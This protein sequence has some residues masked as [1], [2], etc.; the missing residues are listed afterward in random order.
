MA[1]LPIDTSNISARKSVERALAD[2]GGV[3]RLEATW[4]AREWLPP[5]GRLGLPDAKLDAG[6]RGFICERWLGSTTKADNR[7]SL[8][9]EGL[10]YLALSD[11]ARVTLR[12]AVAN[13]PVAIMGAAYAASHDGLSRL[14]KIF[15]FADRFPFHLH[16][17]QEHASLVGRHQK[18]EA[19]WYP[20]GVD[21]GPHPEA[22]LGLHPSLVEPRRHD[23]LLPFL[24]DWNSNLILKHSRAELQVA[25]EGFHVASGILHSPGSALTFELQ[26]DSDVLLMFSAV[27][28]G[29][30]MSKDFLFKDVRPEDRARYGERFALETVDWE[31]N[32]DPLFFE[33]HHTSPQLIESSR[34]PGG[35]AFWIYYNTTK[36][37][38]KKIVV[39]PGAKYTT[40]ERGVYN[41]IVWHGKGT[42]AGLTVD[43]SD[44]T[45]D[46]LLVTHD[47]AV[48]AT[49]IENTGTE[50]MVIVTF[51]GPDVNPDVPMI[52]A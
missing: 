30:P 38:G 1:A 23:D 47:Q 40:T 44:P 52:G 6:E 34:Q 17:R 28:G 42:I 12:E 18:D 37:S 2:G 43:S 29:K 19:Y 39:R 22:F 14:A 50:E 25:D 45:L 8:P 5:L 21:M 9:D 15:D 20:D 16:P 33:H 7:I 13:D 46:E 24:Q 31:A 49:L 27:A 36:F 4:V 35:E 41:L 26:E 11:G 32:C 51:Y 48:K 10:S 3:L